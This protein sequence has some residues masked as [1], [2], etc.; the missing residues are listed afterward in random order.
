MISMNIPFLSL[1]DITAKYRDE[2]HEVVLRVVDS[3]WYLQGK[4]NE[5][6]EKH[7]AEYICDPEVVY[8]TGGSGGGGGEYEIMSTLTE[9][10]TATLDHHTLVYEFY[11]DYYYIG[12][13]GIAATNAKVEVPENAWIESGLYRFGADGSPISARGISEGVEFS[14]VFNSLSVAG[15]G[16]KTE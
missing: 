2:I 11:G 1:H 7:Y 13:D 8:F 4:E 15:A 6:F 16:E 12:K 3:G 9:D 14:I 5:Q 10:H